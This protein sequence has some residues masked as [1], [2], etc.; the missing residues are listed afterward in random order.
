MTAPKPE[1]ASWFS[2]VRRAGSLQQ[3][4]LARL[5]LGRSELNDIH[6]GADC[7]PPR[8]PFN[9][10]LGHAASKPSPRREPLLPA[11]R[12]AMREATEHALDSA[13]HTAPTGTALIQASSSVAC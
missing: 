7:P 6:S 12:K 5:P 3:S 1:M 9:G 2:W 11:E 10:D 13:P 8:S 4:A